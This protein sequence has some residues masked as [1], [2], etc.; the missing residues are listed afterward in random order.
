[1]GDGSFLSAEFKIGV[2]N[3][4]FGE[5]RGGRSGGFGGGGRREGGFG[6]G[7]GGGRREGGFGG[8]RRSFGGSNEPKPVKEGEEHTVT[9]TEISQRGDGIARIK[10]FVVFVPGTQ[11]DDVV[12]IRIK[13]VKGN[14][15]IGEVIGEGS[16]KNEH[17]EEEA[18]ESSE[19]S[20]DSSEE[21]SEKSEEEEESEEFA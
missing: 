4:P 17:I 19:K 10:N 11:K 6:G 16:K 1:M 13:E 18:E 5:R 21:E 15:A 14:H 7:F 2:V 20:A 8:G 9:I 3:M 12:K